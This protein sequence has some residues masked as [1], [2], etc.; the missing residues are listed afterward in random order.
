MLYITLRQL[1]YVVAVARAGS[2]SEA[3]K[4]LGVSQP[5]LS[6]AITQVEDRLGLKLFICKFHRRNFIGPYFVHRLAALDD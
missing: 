6:V 4:T 5:S 1:E 2:L 3:A